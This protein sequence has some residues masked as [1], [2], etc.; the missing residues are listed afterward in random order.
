MNLTFHLFDLALNSA[1][2]TFQLKA[3]M[4]LFAN[5]D[6]IVYYLGLIKLKKQTSLM[7]TRC[8][9][10]TR[11]FSSS[12]DRSAGSSRWKA[13]RFATF[14]RDRFELI[15]AGIWKIFSNGRNIKW[16]D[17]GSTGFWKLGVIFHHW[18]LVLALWGDNHGQLIDLTSPADISYK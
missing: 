12:V 8:R 11:S 17:E 7:Q 10:S 16:D 14:R 18:L 6:V 1:K 5:Y 13:F 9:T 3:V 15:I 4:T 2:S